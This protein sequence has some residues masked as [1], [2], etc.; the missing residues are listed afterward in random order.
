MINMNPHLDPASSR[1]EGKTEMLKIELDWQNTNL[2]CW[3]YSHNINWRTKL[4]NY[5]RYWPVLSLVTEARVWTRSALVTIIT[6][7]RETGDW[8]VV[9]TVW[10]RAVTVVAVRRV[11]RQS[12]QC[13][14]G[15]W[16][17][18]SVCLHL[19]HQQLITINNNVFNSLNTSTELFKEDGWKVVVATAC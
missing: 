5:L 1:V 16:Q 9:F 10:T 19:H 11:A 3:K 4:T 12:W 15:S 14:R 13:C 2:H 7:T 8:H 18:H 6:M 17:S